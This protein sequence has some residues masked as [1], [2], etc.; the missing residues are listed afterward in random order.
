MPQKYTELSKFNPYPSSMTEK[1]LRPVY[2][3]GLNYLG[4]NV[5]IVLPPMMSAQ[6]TPYL[7]GKFLSRYEKIPNLFNLRNVYIPPL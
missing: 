5:I 2:P 6:L 1:I 4:R 7:H 3:L